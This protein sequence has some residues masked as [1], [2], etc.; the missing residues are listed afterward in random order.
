MI[1]RML[2]TIT[3]GAT[4]VAACLLPANPAV[5]APPSSNA[6]KL[7]GAWQVHTADIRLGQ[8]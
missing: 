8:H 7:G 1:T 2:K 4:V 3:A 6:Y 5:A